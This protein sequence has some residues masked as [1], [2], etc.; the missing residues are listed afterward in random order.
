MLPLEDVEV[1]RKIFKELIKIDL[2]KREV[3][4][5]TE[6]LPLVGVG[7]LAKVDALPEEESL[8]E[9]G[10]VSECCETVL[11]KTHHPALPDDAS[12]DVEEKAQFEALF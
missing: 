12:L 4:S 2:E 1:N 9:V 5:L 8:S 10:G 7:I 11:S 6:F 3:K